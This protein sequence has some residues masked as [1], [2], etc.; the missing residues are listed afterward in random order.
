[1]GA[2]AYDIASRY[3]D[4]WQGNAKRLIG[5]WKYSIV[6]PSPDRRELYSY[7][8][9]FTLVRALL[10]EDGSVRLW[11]L[12]GDTYSPTTTRHQGTV[13]RHMQSDRYSNNHHSV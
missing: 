9:H 8:S 6:F 1:M 5:T 4:Y 10:S 3:V 13:R 11:L 2:S 7:G 12:N